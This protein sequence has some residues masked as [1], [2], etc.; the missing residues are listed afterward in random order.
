MEKAIAIAIAMAI[1]ARCVVPCSAVGSA[2]A[3]R[4]VVSRWWWARQ[5]SA[6]VAAGSEIELAG[7]A[8]GA[9]E[10]RRSGRAVWR[11]AVVALSTLR[12]AWKGI[13]G[14]RR[15]VCTG[16][17]NSSSATDYGW[18]VEPSS[19]GHWLDWPKRRVYL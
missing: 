14:G 12:P 13:V 18:R 5:S 17:A 2:L 15:G 10:R 9:R 4:A 7:S 11:S 1:A 8:G 3:V 19:Y 6:C 16:E